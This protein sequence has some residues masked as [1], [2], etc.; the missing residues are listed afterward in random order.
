MQ[1]AP[2][3]FCFASRV[4]VAECPQCGADGDEV[5]ADT[6]GRLICGD[7][8]SIL[9]GGSAIYQQSSAWEDGSFATASAKPV[10]SVRCTC[11]RRLREWHPACE[12]VATRLVD[13]LGE[14]FTRNMSEM[15][16]KRHTQALAYLAYRADGQSVTMAHL[17]ADILV[18]EE[19]LSKDVKSIE[20]KLGLCGFVVA[21]TDADAFAAVLPSLVRQDALR[22]GTRIND[23]TRWCHSLFKRSADKGDVGFLNTSPR[24]QALA[25]LVVYC[26]RKGTPFSTSYMNAYV[27]SKRNRDD[28]K[29]TKSML[30][31][32]SKPPAVKSAVSVMRGVAE[33]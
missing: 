2:R 8:G 23:V 25:A 32:M 24:N 9:P 3:K 7:C 20:S 33:L 26:E 10:A 28:T 4:H 13:D 31:A 19:R 12:S 22:E 29:T 14:G 21:E 27:G 30:T 1:V 16:Q 5:R 15:D 11:L 18:P 6:S 17:A